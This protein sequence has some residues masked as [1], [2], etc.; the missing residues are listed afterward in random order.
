VSLKKKGEMEMALKVIFVCDKC[1]KETKLEYILDDF[2][3]YT[4]SELFHK[5]EN[6]DCSDCLLDELR[7]DIEDKN[8]Q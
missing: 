7:E 4:V 2:R 8:V 5:F 1:G 6:R 3:L